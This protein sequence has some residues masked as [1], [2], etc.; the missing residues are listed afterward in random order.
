MLVGAITAGEQ[1]QLVQAFVNNLPIE[2][3]IAIPGPVF[4]ACLIP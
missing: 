2:P 3:L 4:S 1:V